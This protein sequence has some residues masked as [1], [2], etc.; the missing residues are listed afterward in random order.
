MLPLRV[1]AAAVVGP[2]HGDLESLRARDAHRHVAL[3]L[4]YPRAFNTFDPL[5]FANSTVL[6][7]K[8]VKESPICVGHHVW[9]G[10]AIHVTGMTPLMA[11]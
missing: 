6:W 8:I 4:S 3:R 10:V 5:Y 2:L 1:V 9:P 7:F 11:L